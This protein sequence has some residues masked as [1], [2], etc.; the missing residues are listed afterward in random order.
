[1]PNLKAEGRVVIL[2]RNPAKTNCS[3]GHFLTQEEV[4]EQISLSDFDLDRI[5]T[6]LPQHNLYVITPK[7]K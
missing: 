6:F 4:L 1:M 7:N 5:E 2:D 3:P